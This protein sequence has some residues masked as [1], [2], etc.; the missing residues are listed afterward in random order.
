MRLLFCTVLVSMMECAIA[1]AGDF[2]VD[3]THQTWSASPMPNGGTYYSN[4]LDVVEV[5]PSGPSSAYAHGWS[6]DGR[7]TTSTLYTTPRYDLPREALSDWWQRTAPAAARDC[8]RCEPER[9]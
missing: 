7:E 1:S 3:A 9:R 8:Y 2:S 5:S 6:R 4:G